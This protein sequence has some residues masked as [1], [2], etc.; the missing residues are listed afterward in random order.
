MDWYFVP[1]EHTAGRS[2]TEAVEGIYSAALG[3]VPPDPYQESYSVV[4]Q[5]ITIPADALSVELSFWY[6][7]FTEGTEW[8]GAEDVSWEGFDPQ[9][10][11][12]GQMPLLNGT[13]GR[14]QATD[15]IGNWQSY[16]WQMLILLDSSYG[17]DPADVL[18]HTRSNSGDWEYASFDLSSY[19]GQTRYL[20]FC[21][22]NR[23]WGG[24]RTWMYVDDVSVQSCDI[25]TLVPTHTPTPTRT[26]TPTL[27]YTPSVTPTPTKT[28]TP[29]TTPSVT[30]SMTPS[31]T[32]T[33]T[34]TPSPTLPPTWDCENVILNGDF[35]DAESEV[36][37]RPILIARA[38]YSTV[39]A[40]EG[41]QSMRCGIVHPTP[42]AWTESS[43]YQTVAIPADAERVELTFWYKPY[44]EDTEWSNAGELN[45]EG[46]NPADA[47]LGHEVHRE[48]NESVDNLWSGIDSQQCL[49]LAPGSYGLLAKVLR[50]NS[51]SRIWTEVTYDL[52]A[53][54]GQSI[55]IYFNVINNGIGNKRTWMYV[56][57]VEVNVCR[58]ATVTPPPP[59]PT[60]PYPYPE[61][62]HDD[63]ETLLDRLVR[64]VTGR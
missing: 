17:F 3:I 50:E 28:Y 61:A 27:T 41:V 32:Y 10:L 22:F 15:S 49:I 5:R 7:P 63:G 29:T 59:T 26:R 56:D 42:D 46:F 12:A 8:T 31:P 1:T 37:V 13:G 19:R 24:G 39:T 2:S 44:T 58:W 20:H 23:G 47:I 9:H 30:P 45:W 48:I 62:S 34:P 57:E 16:D 54:R 38:E 11:M 4:Q 33:T 21:V 35:E 60:M 18:L 43:V 52:G 55:V 40:H 53:Y 36:W 51:D 64:F 25:P 6:K 14:N